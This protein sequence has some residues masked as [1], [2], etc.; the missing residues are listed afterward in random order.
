M[1]DYIPSWMTRRVTYRKGDGKAD[2]RLHL[3]MF[4]MTDQGAQKLARYEDAGTPEFF[5]KL[6]SQSDAKSQ[7]LL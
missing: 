5:E 4:R 1:K 6:A 7:S 3:G 2:F